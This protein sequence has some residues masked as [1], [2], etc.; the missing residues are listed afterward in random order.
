M[1][2]PTFLIILVI[3]W[4][5]L[6]EKKLKNYFW[7][8]FKIILLTDIVGSCGVHYPITNRVVNEFRKYHTI[9]YRV[10]FR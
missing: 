9:I 2:I 3:H 6:S 10:V 5:Y 7:L 4:S 1:C 8:F